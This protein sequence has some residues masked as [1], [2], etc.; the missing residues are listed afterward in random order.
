MRRMY[1]EN[2]LVNV[3]ENKDVVAK[4]L[5]QKQANWDISEDF[6]TSPTL[7]TGLTYTKSYSAFKEIN[8]VIY[9]VLN[10]TIENTTESAI[11]CNFIKYLMLSD[12]IAERIIDFDGKSAKESNIA[13]ICSVL[14][15]YGAGSE[16]YNS[17][18]FTLRNY[19]EANE[20]Q[21]MNVNATSIPANSKM[22]FS[23]R[24]FLTLI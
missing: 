17:K 11:N 19:N 24:F 8:G 18:V 22:N 3:L 12:E 6:G 16:L 9:V 1:S 13:N 7:A 5:K 15:M 23:L 2:Q 4:T 21:L 10:Y 20:I 14:C